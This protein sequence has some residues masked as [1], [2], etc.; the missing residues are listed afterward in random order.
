MRPTCYRAV[1]VF[2]TVASAFALAWSPPASARV[3]K[4]TINVHES[5][6]YGGQS[7]GT[8]GQFE[9]LIGTAAGELDPNDRR[10]AII[11]DIQLAPRNARG[12][13]EYVATF[14]LIK[15]IDMSKGNGGLLY[16]VV[17]RGGRGQ[18]YNLGGDPGVTIS[19]NF[20]RA[21]RMFGPE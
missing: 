19:L 2:A 17:N 6:T 12:M 4:L 15:P 16:Q 18:A 21:F 8:V 11:Q 13:V 9:K 3:T 20:S 10:N 5:P 14:T 1:A 7:F